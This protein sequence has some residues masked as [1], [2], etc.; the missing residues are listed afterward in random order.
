MYP[1]HKHKFYRGRDKFREII[2]TVSKVLKKEGE[3]GTAYCYQN[4]MK[5]S[6]PL[7]MKYILRGKPFK[8]DRNLYFGI[9]VEDR[10]V[11]LKKIANCYYYSDLVF[12]KMFS[13]GFFS[14]TIDYTYLLVLDKLWIEEFQ[15]ILNSDQVYYIIKNSVKFN[16]YEEASNTAGFH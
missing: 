1:H 9:I 14:R 12:D 13:L 2:E 11:V 7:M 4:F 6:L 3:E 15:K 8:I 16:K 5:H 10:K